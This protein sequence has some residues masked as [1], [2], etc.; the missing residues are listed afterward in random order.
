MTFHPTQELIEKLDQLNEG[1]GV[2]AEF[3]KVYRLLHEKATFEE[4][5]SFSVAFL[6]SVCADESAA[7][8]RPSV[9]A[10]AYLYYVQYYTPL[11]QQQLR[12]QLD[13]MHPSVEDSTIKPE[14]SE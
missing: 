6:T 11:W 1:K 2:K 3:E 4:M 12:S 5:F 7:H 8:F 10:L 13:L 14:S 9:K